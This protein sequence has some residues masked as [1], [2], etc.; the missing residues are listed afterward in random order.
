MS[1]EKTHIKYYDK[2]SSNADRVDHICRL[3]D[4]EWNGM[5]TRDELA[6]RLNQLTDKWRKEDNAEKRMV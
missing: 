5:I 2:M 4:L 6:R 1:K 3:V